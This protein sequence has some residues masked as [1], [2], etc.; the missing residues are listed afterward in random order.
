MAN[1]EGIE[2]EYTVPVK[3]G[4]LVAVSYTNRII[5]GVVKGTGKKGNL[6][7]Y[8]LNYMKYYLDNNKKSVLKHCMFFLNKT[9]K[10]RFIQVDP[11]TLND[12]FR[13]A[14]ECIIKQMKEV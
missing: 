1:Y 6:Q 5:L 2:T 8:S 9:D 3:V 11:S 14:Y 13:E 12:R 7:Y 4:D 10:Q